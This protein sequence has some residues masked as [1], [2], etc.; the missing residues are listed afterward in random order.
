MF[1][2]RAQNM[3]ITY[4]PAHP[5]L[6]FIDGN[7]EIEGSLTVRSLSNGF[8]E[9]LVIEMVNDSSSNYPSSRAGC[10]GL[11]PIRSSNSSGSVNLSSVSALKGGV[12]VQQ[13][14]SMLSAL[15]RQR[16]PERRFAIRA[17]TSLPVAE[18]REFDGGCS[19]D[20]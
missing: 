11:R 9:C 6:P 2:Y 12:R 10:E 14:C 20:R 4:H 15:T 3:S 18:C 17:I 7:S 1:K 13:P 16:S 19:W 5:E 8:L